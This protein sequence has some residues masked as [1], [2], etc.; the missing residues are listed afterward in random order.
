[1]TDAHWTDR[2]DGKNSDI[3]SVLLDRT[4]RFVHRTKYFVHGQNILSDGQIVFSL[5]DKTFCPKENSTLFVSFSLLAVR[6]FFPSVR[7]ISKWFKRD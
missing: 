6:K 5:I 1:M 3:C 4:K 2:L 7:K